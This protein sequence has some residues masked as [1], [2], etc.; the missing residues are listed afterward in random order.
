M[1][2][3]QGF[4]RRLNTAWLNFTLMWATK[5]SSLRRKCTEKSSQKLMKYKCFRTFYWLTETVEIQYTE[6]YTTVDCYNSLDQF[7]ANVKK[8]S[9]DINTCSRARPKR[10]CKNFNFSFNLLLFWRKLKSQFVW[11]SSVR[12]YGCKNR[13]LKES[14]RTVGLNALYPC[15]H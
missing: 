9:R 5:I 11:H 4:Q 7:C 15:K 3:I 13:D 8:S 10:L 6:K 14:R 2:R 1:S 12:C